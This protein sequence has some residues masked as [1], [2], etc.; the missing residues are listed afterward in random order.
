MMK[1]VFF[2]I[3][4]GLAGSVLA[5]AGLLSWAAFSLNPQDSLFDR[6]P[7]ALNLFLSAWIT[8]AVMGAV[9]GFRAF[10]TKVH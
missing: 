4:G 7:Q 6:D 10:R 1:R 9:V 8:L 2:T 5:W 3:L